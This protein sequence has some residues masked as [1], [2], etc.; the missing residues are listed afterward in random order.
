MVTWSKLRTENPE[1]FSQLSGCVQFLCIQ[2]KQYVIDKILIMDAAGCM[3]NQPR[4]TR[5]R[6]YH[7][8][9]ICRHR[10]N[11]TGKTHWERSQMFIMHQVLQVFNRQISD[12]FRGYLRR[13]LTFCDLLH[14]TSENVPQRYVTFLS[15]A[16]QNET[17]IELDLDI[18]PSPDVK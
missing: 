10:L 1:I 2:S 11:T 15:T 9:E 7:I 14:A 12:M 18:V 6:E 13:L 4:W 17:K 3:A 8:S 16:E 5:P